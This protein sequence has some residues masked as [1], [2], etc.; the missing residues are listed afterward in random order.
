MSYI[1]YLRIRLTSVERHKGIRLSIKWFLFTSISQRVFRHATF[2]RTLLHL[3]VWLVYLIIS[4]NHISVEIRGE[5]SCNITLRFDGTHY[6][7]TTQVRIT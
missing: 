7:C 3:G 4:Q 5:R 2:L 6:T 1:H